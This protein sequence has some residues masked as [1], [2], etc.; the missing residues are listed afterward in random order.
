[1]DHIPE[2][3]AGHDGVERQ[4]ERAGFR[5]GQKAEHKVVGMLRVTTTERLDLHLGRVRRHAE[6]CKPD[7]LLVAIMSAG[8]EFR[9][10]RKSIAFRALM[11]KMNAR[12]TD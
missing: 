6:A 9:E 8:T 4:I 2:R 5:L 7:G 11:E 12:W 3:L 1:Q 10:T